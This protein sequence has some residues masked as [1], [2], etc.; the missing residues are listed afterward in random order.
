[1]IGFYIMK[2]VIIID[3]KLLKNMWMDKCCVKL[4]D[5]NCKSLEWYWMK[6]YD[7]C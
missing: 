3:M 5:G 1:M 4:I 2:Y 6:I 7:L